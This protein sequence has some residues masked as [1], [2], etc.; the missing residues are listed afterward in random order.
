MEKNRKVIITGAAGFIGSHITQFFCEKGIDIVCFV[1]KSSNLQHIKNLPVEISYGDITDFNSLKEAFMNVDFVIHTAGFA[2]DW[3]ADY[4]EVYEIN[5]TGT[6][7]VL[8]ACYENNIKDVIITGS[9]SS[10]G[11][12]SSSEL[13]N[14]E[15]PYNSHYKYFLN[16]IFPSK[17][18]YYTDTKAIL[19][20]ESVKYASEQGLNLTII[21]PA[22]VYGEREF[23]TGFYEY[24]KTVKTKI[25]VMPG[26]KKNK[27][28]VIY[29]GDL[30]RAYFL[31][32]QKRLPGINRIVV[33]NKE[34]EYMNNMYSIFC[35]ELGIKKPLNLPRILTYP[36]GFIL[37]LFYTIFSIKTPPLLSRNRVNMLYNNI[38]YSVKK[39][40]KVLSF[41]NEYS[42]EE[43]IKKTVK[44]YKD[45][46]YL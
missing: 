29:A 17:M 18:N 9:I 16:S 15:S 35:K 40:E 21:E 23:N 25:P 3:G 8:K 26:S 12:E 31:A 22:W 34:S 32:Y 27:F 2:K 1:K 6:L 30:A 38:E 45:N 14:E 44:W 41:T 10:Y 4:K 39:A 19:T 7:N 11:E 36:I 46:N 33:G 42:L 28:H 5:V 43:G 37:E 20:K 24:M 13:K